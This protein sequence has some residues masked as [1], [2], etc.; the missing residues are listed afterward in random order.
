MSLDSIKKA[1]NNIN[2]TPSNVTNIKNIYFGKVIDITDEFN[3]GTIK[4]FIQGIDNS[5]N[6]NSIPYSY[7]LLSRIFYVAPKIGEIVL[8]IVSNNSNEF[9]NKGNRFWIGPLLSNYENIF[10]DNYDFNSEIL[11]T[12]NILVDPII[13]KSKNNKKI[14]KNIFPITNSN[15]NDIAILGRNNSDVI[16]SDNKITIR[17]GK[18]KNNNNTIVNN[19]NPSYST[20]GLVDD[21]QSYIINQSDDIFLISHKGKNIVKPINN[22]NDLNNL[23]NELESILYGESTIKYLK[24]LTYIL[25]NHIHPHSQNIP[26]DGENNEYKISDLINELNNIENLLAKHIKIN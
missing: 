26:I 22:E 1:S 3:V 15:I 10:N 11:L 21:K 17:A 23:K 9:Q 16:L 13:N 18:H 2:N 25:L 6:I 19:T 4:V 24:T 14:E 8:V 20:Y 7:P 5:L 12:K